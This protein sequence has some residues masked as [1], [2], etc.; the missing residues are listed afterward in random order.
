MN[1]ICLNITCYPLEL[2]QVDKR[3]FS[4]FTT[5]PGKIES[6]TGAYDFP[7]LYHIDSSSNK[8]I[9]QI[10]VRLVKGTP[11]TY[12]I[13]WDLMLDNTVPIKP[14]Y[15]EDTKLPPSTIAQVWVETGVI[16]GKITRHTPSYPDEKHVGQSN[17]RNVLKAGLVMARSLYLKKIASGFTMLKTGKASQAGKNNTYFPMLVRKYD[18]EKDN[19]TYPV[20]VQPKLDGVRCMAYLNE[21]PSKNPTKKNVILYTRQKKEYTGYDDLRKE[22]LDGLIDMFDIK[23]KESIYID[24]EFYKHGMPLQTIS[25]AV[26]NADRASM[27]EYKGIKFHIFDVFYPSKATMPFHQRLELL[28]DLFDTFNTTKYIEKVPTVMAATPKA[29]EKMYRDFL[30][31]K[32]EG[33]IIRDSTSAYLTHPTK[34]GMSIR[35][36]FVLKRK[37]TYSDEYE[38]TGFTQGSNGRDKGAIIWRCKT[39]GS[40][41]FNATPKNITYEERYKLFKELSKNN[42]KKFD[43][44]YAGRM[45]TVEYEDL[46]NKKVPLRAKAIGFRDHM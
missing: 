45:M 35:S 10:S 26:R 23:S 44:E 7:P 17:E 41:K 22:L 15:L 31:R 43:D 29:E 46:S 34:T 20:Y 13:D 8:R 14:A 3:N 19:L 9:W 30:K 1:F 39:K 24:G 12:G 36:K 21:H 27:D 37:M 4:D 5:F 42:G 32:Y 11:K 25:G 28:N 18:D 38:V 6:E 16:S 33:V 40:A 2:M